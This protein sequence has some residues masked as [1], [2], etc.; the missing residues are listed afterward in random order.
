MLDPY[1]PAT[2]N[3]Q[4]SDS[5]L[6]NQMLYFHT[7]FDTEKARHKVLGTPKAGEWNLVILGF[8]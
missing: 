1:R 5:R 4:Y 3:W 7:L 8:P 6:Y 2:S